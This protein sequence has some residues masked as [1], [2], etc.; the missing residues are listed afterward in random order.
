MAIEP[1]LSPRIVVGKICMNPNL[2]NKLLNQRALR[3]AS[4][5]AIYSASVDDKAVIDC[6]LENQ[7]IAPPAIMKTYPEVNFWLSALAKVASA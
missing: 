3:A 1:L 5:K 4:D 6:F 2:R 7:V